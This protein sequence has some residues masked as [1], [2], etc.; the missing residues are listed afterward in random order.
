[1]IKK[2]GLSVLFLLVLMA[3]NLVAQNE[4]DSEIIPYEHTEM[5]ATSIVD[6]LQSGELMLRQEIIIQAPIEKIWSAY[7][8]AEEW[9]EWVTPIVEIDFRINGTIKSHYDPNAK[10]GDAGTIVIHILNY[11]PNKLITMQAEIA[12]NFPDFIK[13]EEKNMF[14]LVEF[15]KLE[16]NSTK[17]TLYG[18]GYRNEQ[19]WLDLMNF[20]IEGNEMTLMN[21]K[22]YVEQ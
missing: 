6:T 21:L 3:N 22:K 7:T 16:S 12:N 17:V 18:I 1:M 9:K 11:I 13:G 10:I 20:F 8:T 19:R 5:M 2:I 4:L 15:T 14:S